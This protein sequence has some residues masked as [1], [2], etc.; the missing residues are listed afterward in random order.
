MHPYP[1]QAPGRSPHRVHVTQHTHR[2]RGG[3]LLLY[4]PG[5]TRYRRQQ[6]GEPAEPYRPESGFLGIGQE[7]TGSFQLIPGLQR[8]CAVAHKYLYINTGWAA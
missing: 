8:A 5:F 2:P 6:P 4:L 3:C 7:M 1:G